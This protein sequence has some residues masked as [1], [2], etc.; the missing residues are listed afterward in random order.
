[1]RPLPRFAA[2]LLAAIS[3]FIAAPSFA[4]DAYGM[5][6]ESCAA[7]PEG[8]AEVGNGWI[9]V[10]ESRY[11]RKSPKRDL[12]D[13][14]F[15]AE[16]ATTA[17]GEEIGRQRLRL[18]ITPDMLSMRFLSGGTGIDWQ[19]CAILSGQKPAAATAGAIRLD[20]DGGACNS[21]SV[22]RVDGDQLTARVDLRYFPG[23]DQPM[24]ITEIG[25]DPHFPDRV[26]RITARHPV[27]EQPVTYALVD[28]TSVVA[29][30]SFTS[31][32]DLDAIH[33]EGNIDVFGPLQPCD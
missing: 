32:S 2:P 30:A 7:P 14:W 3:L 19:S 17:E 1:M 8:Y 25:P 16:Y 13:G 33:Q 28:G 9:S 24:Q 12:G 5:S 27:I 4:A 20:S 15:E 18:R 10:T 29:G 6:A 21:D 31:A 22:F 26:I 23:A 11:E